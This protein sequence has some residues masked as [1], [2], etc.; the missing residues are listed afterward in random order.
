MYLTQF[1]HRN[2]QRCPGH[3]ALVS[4]EGRRTHGQLYERVSR[5]AAGLRAAGVSRGERVALL[6]LNSLEAVEIMLACWWTGAVFCPVNT[7]WSVPEIVACLSDC[8]PGLLFVDAANEA[9]AAQASA[10][11]Q[12]MR[13]IVK[14]SSVDAVSPGF[15]ALLS[16]AGDLEDERAA[17]DAVAVLMYTGGTTG[18]SKGVLLT[19]QTLYAAGM[20]RVADS[21]PLHD[22]ITM[23]VTP[24]FHVAGVIRLIPHL[25]AGGT[26]VVLAQF[27]AEEAMLM[28]EREGV[29][30]LAM[31]P[32]MLQM[33]LEHPEFTPERLRSVKRL[34][35]G[36]AP[37]ARALLE[38]VTRILPGVGLYQ[39][40]GM[41]E[42]M[43][44][45][46]MSSPADHR[47]EDWESGRAISAGQACVAAELRIVDETGRDVAPGQ[48]GE[49]MLRGPI[50]SPG[51]WNRPEE[52]AATFRDGWLHTGDA[53]R[54]DEHGYLYV[55]DRI[56]DMIVTGGENVYSAEVENAL[57]QHPGVASA[58]VIGIPSERWGEAV[59]AVVVLKPGASAEAATLLAHCRGLVAAYKVPKSVE[60]VSDLPLTAA[61]KVAKTQLREKHW[62]GRS[63][64]VN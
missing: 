47:P 29:V 24:I 62:R 23:M 45:G 9:A 11:V 37:S 64:S 32:S 28:I 63:R 14:I 5:L 30:E 42:S 26:C 56:K 4:K 49:I 10:Q 55:V 18:R 40:Y 50:V 12:G 27:K 17:E 46:T 60:F 54:L 25:M 36:A 58:A 59:H 15:E 2:L 19:H 48:V 6:S 16:H 43:G 34:H 57:S 1:L 51:Y 21:E 52:T 31:V 53:G 22:S 38:R 8:S 61:G 44:T 20:A 13:A 41:T 39:A 3:T 35:Y 7:R 33:I